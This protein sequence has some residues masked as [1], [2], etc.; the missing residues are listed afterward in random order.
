MNSLLA[1]VLIL[2]GV[3]LAARGLSPLRERLAPTDTIK[4]PPTDNGL[5][6]QDEIDRIWAMIPETDKSLWVD[7]TGSS[8]R[9]KNEVAI[10]VRN[11][12]MEVYR[13]SQ[14]PITSQQVTDYA[15]RPGWNTTIIEAVRSLLHA[16]FIDQDVPAT[17][18]PIDDSV[19]TESTPAPIDGAGRATITI[20]VT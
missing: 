11:F 14:A 10:V 15:Y 16:Y 2:L 3:Y 12:Y 5:Y 8:G 9:A 17:P 6:S 1:V 7:F 13:P 4:A 20:N 18:A 19:P